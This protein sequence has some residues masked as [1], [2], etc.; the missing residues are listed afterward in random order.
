MQRQTHGLALAS[1]SERTQAPVGEPLASDKLSPNDLRIARRCPNYSPRHFFSFGQCADANPE[2]TNAGRSQSQAPLRVGGKNKCAPRVKWDPEPEYSLMALR[3]GY[4][5]VCVLRLIVDT[6][7]KPR[8]IKVALARLGVGRESDRSSSTLGFEPAMKDGK[9]VAV[10]INVE[11][12]FRKM[13]GIGSSSC[14]KKYKQ[15]NQR[16]S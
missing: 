3:L 13:V 15:A 10:Q 9:P 14:L 2:S 6:D 12:N 8:D 1:M 11:V 16:Q 7:G 4:Q 5:G